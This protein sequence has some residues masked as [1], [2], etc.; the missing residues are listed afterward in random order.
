MVHTV[1]GFGIVFSVHQINPDVPEA[2]KWAESLVI[3]SPYYACVFYVLEQMIE[4]NVY[5]G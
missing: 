4:L 1:K 3:R 5:E 2:Q